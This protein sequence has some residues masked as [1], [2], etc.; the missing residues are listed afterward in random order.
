MTFQNRPKSSQKHASSCNLSS[1]YHSRLNSIEVNGGIIVDVKTETNLNSMHP[2][3]EIIVDLNTM[4]TLGLN[5][6]LY[7]D[8]YGD[9]YGD[10]CV[11]LKAYF[12]CIF[13]TRSKCI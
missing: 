8:L 5:A 12:Q 13:E 1:K 9:L 4:M 6:D 3:G 7:V 2:Y 11:K 10:L